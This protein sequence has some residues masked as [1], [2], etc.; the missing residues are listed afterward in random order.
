M[1]IDFDEMDEPVSFQLTA[2]KNCEN[3][4]E[5]KNIYHLFLYHNLIYFCRLYCRYFE[6]I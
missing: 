2:E 1:V 4:D 5:K 3:T 6:C